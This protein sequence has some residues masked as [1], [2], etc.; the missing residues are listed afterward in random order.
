MSRS[1][2]G[3]SSTPPGKLGAVS[4]ALLLLLAAGC[5]ADN[6]GV[7]SSAR[8]VLAYP[9]EGSVTVGVRDQRPEIVSGERRE[10]FIGFQRSLYGIPFAVQT[11]SGKSFAR[12]LG[13]LIARG[14]AARGARAEVVDLSPVRPREEAIAALAAK[15]ATRALLFEVAEWYGDTYARTTLH[16]D[17]RLTVLDAQGHELG[18]AHAAGEDDLGSRQRPERQT[19]QAATQDILQTLLSDS[20]I[21]AARPP[22]V[23]PA[24]EGKRC[25]V[26]QILKMREAGLAEEQIKAACGEG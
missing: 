6:R 21:R 19:V 3:P 20:G 23:Q 15:G 12:E 10:A 2:A 14:L 16:Y 18:S 7:Y 11:R 13:E 8:P 1:I 25:T 17:L 24:G 26:E 4:R 9:G 22:E 5:A